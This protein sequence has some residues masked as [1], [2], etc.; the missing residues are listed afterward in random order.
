MLGNGQWEDVG[1]LTLCKKTPSLVFEKEVNFTKIF[2]FVAHYN[3][4]RSTLNLH[5]LKKIMTEAPLKILLAE[6]L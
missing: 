3:V 5:Y 2:D 4:D 6:V 1:I